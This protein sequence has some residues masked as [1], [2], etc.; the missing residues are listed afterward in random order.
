[1]IIEQI[2][3]DD[4]NPLAA[5]LLEGESAIGGGAGPTI[6][7]PTKLIALG[8]KNLSAEEI[9]AR[10]RAFSPPIISRISEGKVLLDLRTVFPN[11][12]GQ[13]IAAL[14]SIR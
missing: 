3:D 5:V 2:L 7:L 13:V 14:K 6:A 8:H 9:G 1:M 12:E 10:L 11:E 4:S